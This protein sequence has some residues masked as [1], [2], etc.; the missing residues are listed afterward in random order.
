METETTYLVNMVLDESAEPS[1]EVQIEMAVRRVSRRANGPAHQDRM[2]MLRKEI[3]ELEA[4]WL[5][6]LRE[7][8]GCQGE[9]EATIIS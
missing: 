2:T 8:G 4:L 9:N 3:D 7:K 1:L 6:F 5:R